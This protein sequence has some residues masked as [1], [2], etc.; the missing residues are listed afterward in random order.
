MARDCR[1]GGELSRIRMIPHALA[2]ALSLALATPSQMGARPTVGPARVLADLGGYTSCAFTADGSAVICS[3]VNEEEISE[4]LWRVDL[5]SGEAELIGH[6]RQPDVRGALLAYVGTE[7]GSEGIWLREMDSD[8]SLKRVT[9]NPGYE[10]P[11]ISPDASTVACARPGDRRGGIYLFHLGEEEEEKNTWLCQ[12]E[13]GQPAYSAD[14]GRM[15]VVRSKQIWIIHNVGPRE[16]IEEQRVTDDGREHLDPSW[17]PTGAWI[18][19]VGRWTQA[20]SNVGVLHLPSGQLTWLTE[21]L[22]AARSPAIS[23]TGDK[24]VYVAAHGEGNALHVCDL[25]LP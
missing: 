6:G 14:G 22:T 3:R 20:A 16:E 19:F 11:S 24:L 10:W 12:R 21:G 4:E 9:E 8:D 5:A 15:L 1:T 7:P 2:L 25:R 23:P 18:V 13:E 17:G